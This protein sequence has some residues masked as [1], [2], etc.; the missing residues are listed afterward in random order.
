MNQLERQQ[1][2]KKNISLALYSLMLHK[3]Y[4]EISVSEIC[5]KAS[6]SRVSFYHYYDKKDD[7]LI[8][9]SD[10]RF[11]EFF[12]DFT[13]LESLTFEDLILQMF[14]FL[15][16]NSRQL[17]ILRYAKKEDILM[18]QF[19][20][21]CRYIFSNNITSPIIKNKDNP[22]QIP[23][24]VGGIFQIIMRWLDEGMVSTPET[25]AKY[26]IDIVK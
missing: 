17:A 11:A 15:K 22:L 7:I 8:Q 21:Y 14:I 16:K 18:E 5:Q 13:K 9:Y 6:I 20:S 24:L 19:Y 4:E 23:F 1:R 12:E 25:M 26:V 2:T 10:E 3:P